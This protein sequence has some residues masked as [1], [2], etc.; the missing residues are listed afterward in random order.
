MTESHNSIKYLMW[1]ISEIVTRIIVM[2]NR[3]GRTCQC[4]SLYIYLK[5]TGTHAVSIFQTIRDSKIH[6]SSTQRGGVGR[7]LFFWPILFWLFVV[8]FIS[9]IDP[10]QCENRLLELLRIEWYRL[11]YFFVTNKSVIRLQWRQISMCYYIV[12]KIKYTIA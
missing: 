10:E 8:I 9:Y 4:Y 7:R 2:V 3:R 5:F 6:N 12:S 11:V 1:W